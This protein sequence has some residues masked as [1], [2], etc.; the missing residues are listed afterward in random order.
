[1]EMRLA[2]LAKAGYFRFVDWLHLPFVKSGANDPYHRLYDEFVS[3]GMA[4]PAP[5]VLN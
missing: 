3:I 2:N 5:A 4:L 1:M